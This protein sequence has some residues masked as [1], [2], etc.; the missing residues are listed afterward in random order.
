ML[1]KFLK[2]SGGARGYADYLQAEEVYQRDPTTGKNLTDL[3]KVK[4]AVAPE[5]LRGDFDAVVAL[6]EALPFEHTYTAG[7]IAFEASDNPTREQIEAVIDD[8][9]RH[10]APGLEDRTL[11]AWN[12]HTDKGNV[13][14]NFILTRCDLET[15]RSFNVAPPGHEKHFN[16]W[17]DKWNLEQGWASPDDPARQREIKPARGENIERVRDKEAI[18]E[19]LKT[20]ITAGQIPG[21]REGVL[22]ALSELGEITRKPD[23]YISIKL[24][25]TGEKLRLKGSIYRSDFN[26]T[27]T[28]IEEAAASRRPS[29][30]A[31]LEA[32]RSEAERSRRSRADYIQKRYQKSAE[33]ALGL[34]D[35]VPG[36]GPDSLH[37]VG[38][39]RGVDLLENGQPVGS[40][41]GPQRREIPGAQRRLDPMQPERQEQP[42]VPTGA[43]DNDRYSQSKISAAGLSLHGLRKRPDHGLP[44]RRGQDQDRNF[45][46]EN[47]QATGRGPAN[48][49]QRLRLALSNG[50]NH[51]NRVG[52]ALADRIGQGFERIS[53]WANRHTKIVQWAGWQDGSLT[54]A[55]TDLDRAA[56]SK[57]RA[58]VGLDEAMQRLG[59]AVGGLEHQ[60]EHNQALNP[61]RSRGTG[62]GFGR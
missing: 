18:T 49:L 40:A 13:E 34:P 37:S 43:L 46:L 56:A 32:A 23:D 39:G 9:Q 4:R 28:G 42:F 55:S 48:F 2:A 7:V 16:P 47:S 35:R 58:G 29:R 50:V 11:W 22:L 36:V 14:L 1:V 30:A 31:E 60:I 8:F 44:A 59:R 20:L 62:W 57:H 54:A 17:R 15:G 25:S 6:S 53:E 38:R 24:A 5:H 33:V 41:R 3:P 12:M 52:K 19:H 10:A 51:G 26:A 21:N 45:L 61:A 27:T